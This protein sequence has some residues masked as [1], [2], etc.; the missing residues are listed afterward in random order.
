MNLAR[1]TLPRRSSNGSG[2]TLIE[3]LVVIAII[4]I[5]AGMLLPALGKAKSKAQGILCMN[6]GK[7]ITLASRLYSGDNQELLV[8][9]QNLADNPYKRVNWCEGD[10]TDYNNRQNTNINVITNGPLFK[11]VGGALAVFKCPADRSAIGGLKGY[12]GT[13]R[14]RSISMSQVFGN[15]E[16]LNRSYDQR[17]KVW[18]TYAKDSHVIAPSQTWMF[19]DEHP[20]SIN[21]AAFA[22]ACT[23]AQS[24]A[25]KG[26]II[27]MPASTHNGAC[28][29]SFNDGHSEIHRWVGSKIKPPTKYVSGGVGLNVPAGDSQ[30]DVVWMAHNTTVRNN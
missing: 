13:P 16:W 20:D 29:F 6:N 24:M 22:N 12:K 11:F 14:V 18:R 19:V 26:Q 7:Q 10:I 1:P 9:A 28:G 2:F 5:L 23:G 21:D 3:L 17:Q 8:A 4:A 27:D 15:G 25:E 30:T